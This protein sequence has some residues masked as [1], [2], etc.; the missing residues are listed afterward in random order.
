MLSKD[1]DALQPHI[2]AFV[3]RAVTFSVCPECDGS[4]LNEGARSAKINGTNIAEVSAMQISDV[5][6]WAQGLHDASV[7]PLLTALRETLSAFVEIGLGY[8]SLD[9]PAGA[10]WGGEAQGRRR[11]P[12]WGRRPGGVV[13]AAANPGTPDPAVPAG[14]HPSDANR[15][16]GS[17]TVGS[18]WRSPQRACSRGGRA[19]AAT[20][21]RGTPTP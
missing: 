21:T 19:V 10:L 12:G 11:G 5:L 8:L 2:R 4:R 7:E 16:G 17:A 15:R 20:G 14:S 18:G 3:E 13:T 1:V 9:R 6:T